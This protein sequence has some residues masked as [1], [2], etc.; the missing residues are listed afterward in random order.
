MCR[1]YVR[2]R[3]PYYCDGVALSIFT[4]WPEQI[5]LVDAGG[6]RGLLAF[7]LERSVCAAHSA[8]YVGRYMLGVY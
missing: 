8:E 5:R 6:C 2:A 3:K 1:L 4:P 7:Q